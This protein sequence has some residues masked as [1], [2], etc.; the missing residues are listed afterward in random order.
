M[1][2]LMLTSV[3][4]T[5]I[6]SFCMSQE[7]HPSAQIGLTG[8]PIIYLNSSVS[9]ELG[10]ID[11]FAGYITLGKFVSDHIAIGFRPFI[12][13]VNNFG[14]MGLNA[15][16][17]LY[18][19]QKKSRAFVDANAGLGAVWYADEGES[20]FFHFRD[21]TNAMFN[22][23]FG[24]GADFHLKNDFFLEVTAQYLWM[25]DLSAPAGFSVWKSVIPSIG[26]V[27]YLYPSD[28]GG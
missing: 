28:I 24:P 1:K 27:K 26:V 14:S 22:V 18:F 19:G 20:P 7:E 17:R 8:L 9:N 15:Y 4:S 11:G 23:A 25:K 3:L 16:S 13:K 2:K 21:G 10:T 12:G 6:L 5:F